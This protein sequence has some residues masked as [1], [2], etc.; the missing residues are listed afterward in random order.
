MIINTEIIDTYLNEKSLEG[1]KNHWIFNSIIEGQYVIEE[2]NRI[3]EDKLRAVYKI[4]IDKLKSFEPLNKCLWQQFFGGIQIPDTICVYLIVGSPEPYD[5]MVRKDKQ[6]NNCVIL[7]LVRI[8]SYSE[9]ISKLSDIVS[10]FITHEISHILTDH[11]YH[12]PTIE[13][14]LFNNLKHIVFDEGIAHFL[15]FDNDVLLMDWYSDEM[16]IRRKNSYR[17]LLNALKKD[18]NIDKDQILE[19][20]NSGLF[21]EKF[22]AISG[23]FAIIDYFNCNNKDI[24]VFKYIFEKGPDLLIDFILNNQS[25]DL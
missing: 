2:T 19:K 23:L 24:K 3:D 11:I 10:S 7:D 16:N 8:S 15:S 25:L 12:H 4:L 6:G 21:W 20:S 17:I 13:D 18:T 9:D 14:S 22:G 5:A 1:I